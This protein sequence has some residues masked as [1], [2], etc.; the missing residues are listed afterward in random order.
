[1]HLAEFTPPVTLRPHRLQSKLFRTR[2]RFPV[3][4]A[5][6]GSG[7]SEILKRKMVRMLNYDYPECKAAGD[8]PRF[9]YALPTYGQA[10]RVAWEPLKRLLPKDWYETEGQTFYEADM[11]MKTRFGTEL[12]VVGMDK[13]QRIEGNQWKGGVLDECSDQKP[14]VFDRSVRPALT[15]FNGWCV[16]AGVP[17]RFGIGAEDFKKACDQA[18]AGVDPDMVPFTWMSASVVDPKQLEQIKAT[19][20]LTDY[21]EQYEA[22]WGSVSGAIFHNFNENTHVSVGAEYI[23][24]LPIFVGSDF[25]VDPMCWNLHHIVGGKLITFDELT[26][27]NTNTQATLDQLAN[28]YGLHQAGWKFFGDAAAKAR[29]TSASSTDYIQIYN[30]KRF[31]NK[32]VFY[33]DSNPPVADRFAAC[34]ALL[35]NAK[36]DIRAMI[37][38]RCKRLLAD[39]THRCYKPGTREPNDSGQLGHASDAWG[40]IICRLWPVQIEIATAPQIISL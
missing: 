34:N 31:T 29:K 27:R 11:V 15:A 19:T 28:K 25:N 40:Y 39:L 33:F 23:S 13:P 3:V 32:E 20:D 26:I 5:G 2:S 1:M 14:G 37:N 35:K 22:I 6:R 18:L 21:L 36:G 24:G 8:I 10:N 4:W 12:H 9:F 16:R 30:D 38:P 17:K 7:K